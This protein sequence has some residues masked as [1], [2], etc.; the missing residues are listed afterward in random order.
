MKNAVTNEFIEGGE[1]EQMGCETSCGGKEVVDAARG[2]GEEKDA[3]AGGGEVLLEPAGDRVVVISLEFGLEFCAVFVAGIE[4]K[5]HGVDGVLDPEFDVSVGIQG[6][7]IVVQGLPKRVIRW[8][9]R[10]KLGRVCGTGFSDKFCM[11]SLDKEEMWYGSVFHVK[12]ASAMSDK[13]RICRSKGERLGS[14]RS[15]KVQRKLGH[16]IESWEEPPGYKTESKKF[17]DSVFDI[18]RRTVR[19][20][21]RKHFTCH[22]N[23][24]AG[25]DA[26]EFKV[27]VC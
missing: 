10:G 11:G 17:M 1:P 14:A 25:K 27:K 8:N 20:Q 9:P 26:D 19:E 13:G 22:K 15:G 18:P 23:E 12:G 6:E 7:A 24:L 16:G 2:G 5:K 21:Q 3:K 4:F